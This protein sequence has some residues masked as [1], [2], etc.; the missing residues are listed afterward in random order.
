MQTIRKVTWVLESF[1][2]SLDKL[3]NEIVKQGHSFIDHR[4]QPM[5]SHQKIYYVSKIACEDWKEIYE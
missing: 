3:K 1:V 2:E 4:Y 5:S